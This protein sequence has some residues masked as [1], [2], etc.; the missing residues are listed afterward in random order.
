MSCK[1]TPVQLYTHVEAEAGVKSQQRAMQGRAGRFPSL[2]GLQH[3][4]GAVR[5]GG[6][7][8]CAAPW[9]GKASPACPAAAC[10]WAQASRRPGISAVLS[11]YETH[12]HPCPVTSILFVLR[13]CNL[14]N[15]PLLRRR[16]PPSP[17]LGSS[18]YLTVPRS[19]GRP[20]IPPRP[21]RCSLSTLS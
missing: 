3:A 20:Y 17:R 19:L 12:Q 18:T 15:L 5:G 2:A 11:A 14:P 10:C 8:G 16:P 13:L 7:R 4:A 6:C 21:R 9:P 1:Y